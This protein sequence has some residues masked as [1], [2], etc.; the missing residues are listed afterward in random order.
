MRP[1]IPFV[2]MH[3]E[4]GS[5][6]KCLYAKFIW[7][8]FNIVW[9]SPNYGKAAQRSQVLHADSCVPGQDALRGEVGQPGRGGWPGPP[10]PGHLS[11]SLAWWP[12]QLAL[13]RIL[14]LLAC[15]GLCLVK[16]ELEHVFWG[17]GSK[18]RYWQFCAGLGTQTQDR[19]WISLC[20]DNYFPQ[21][22]RG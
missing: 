21:M 12:L 8:C 9:M 7:E 4:G 11:M 16:N 13:E 15:I 18:F 3:E 5:E 1:R 10:A 2:N 19:D 6:W 17:L 14:T 20:L 22:K